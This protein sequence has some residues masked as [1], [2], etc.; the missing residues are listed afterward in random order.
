MLL[1]GNVVAGFG[2]LL[3]ATGFGSWTRL[4][5][6]GVHMRLRVRLPAYLTQRRARLDEHCPLLPPLVAL[7]SSYKEPT[8][9][10][11]LWATGLGAVS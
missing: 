9:T 8:T 10:E 4:V 1:R 7:V 6:E 11:E 5:Q 3:M 2:I